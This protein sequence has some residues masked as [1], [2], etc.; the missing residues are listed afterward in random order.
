MQLL[1]SFGKKGVSLGLAT[2]PVDIEDTTYL[3]KYFSVAEFNPVFT[4]GKNPVSFNG[5]SLLKAGSEI[6]V[7]CI[8]SNGNSL[9]IE[10]P[11]SNTQFSDVAT[12][13]VSVNVFNETYNGPG[14]FVLVGTSVKNEIIRWMADVTI[15]KT[16]Q[17]ASKVRFYNKPTLEARPLLYPVVNTTVATALTYQFVFTGSF[18]SLAASPKKDTTQK[19][20]NPKKTDIDYRIILNAND[21]DT[22]PQLYPTKSFNSQMEGQSFVITAKNI[23]F[24]YSY[25][26]SQI[27]VTSSFKVKKVLDSKTLQLSDA[28]FFPFGQNKVVTNINFGTF[29]SSYKWVAYNTASDSYQKY[30]PLTGSPIFIK[31]SYAE[32][33][34]RNLKTFS[35]FI[36]RHKLYR[37]SLVYP[38]DFQ[39]IA[40]EPLGAFEILTDPITANKSYP[41]LGTFYNQSHINKYWFASTG[42]VSLAMSHSVKPI[43]NAMRI[44]APNGTFP[45]GTTYAIVKAASDGVS[46]NSTY[47]PYDSASFNNLTGS[48]YNSNFISLKGGAQYVLSMNIIMEK[49][50]FSK[51]SKISF[52]FTS[53]I[54]GILKEKDY[55][56]PY[57]LKI[58]EITTREET[59]T[60]TFTDKQMLFF[61]P[62]DDYF[63]TI[64]VV[65]NDCNVTISDLSL[66]VYGDYGF[67]P[68]ILFSKLPFPINIPGEGF[69]LKA[70]LFDVN[71]TL[72]FSD[73]QTIQTFD[74]DGASLF[75]FI[76]NSNV[77]PTKVQFISGSLTLS[78]SLF[79]PNI[80]T[81]P[82]VDTR[83]LAWRIPTHT[84]PQN[85]EGQV[86]HTD[87]FE[88][89]IDD[90]AEG[91]SIQG[92]YLVLGTVQFSGSGLVES[93]ATALSIKYDGSTNK[94]RKIII[95]NSGSKTV[96]P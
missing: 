38:G 36:A 53:S 48:A 95:D 54:P 49:P 25:L 30:T 47:F 6:Q 27:F 24:P 39:L 15:D 41:L 92:D 32:I 19:V 88:L 7:E 61:T 3:S 68:D 12:F 45:D 16:V 78:Q 83:L 65:P 20:I 57:G 93:L 79:L 5:S 58:G 64:V 52:Y 22:S 69:L 80:P 34:Y 73:L 67:S 85:T 9:Y 91:T 77:D 50:K 63:G 23:Q 59:T 72:V 31:Q 4:G 18:S 10:H 55:I 71:S 75:V 37:K 21:T 89:K 96:Y 28:F 13:V 82:S 51:D 90:V 29:T 74:P 2:M 87:I 26:D 43:L 94:G 81:C 86:C 33:V 35:G 46:N 66:K 56:F 14:K 84:P 40:D 11:I 70:E 8:D 62:G 44:A 42:S 1:S 76:P 17:N 60:K